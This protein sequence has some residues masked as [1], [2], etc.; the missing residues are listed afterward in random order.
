[1]EDFF[2]TSHEDI[3]SHIWIADPNIAMILRSAPTL[4]DARE[5]MFEHLNT[6][7]RRL[8]NIYSRK[9]LKDMHIVE[10]NNAKECIRVLKNFIRTENERITGYSAL[11]TLRD[12]A[13]GKQSAREV[14]KGFLLE[15]YHLFMG[16]N[17]RSGIIRTKLEFKDSEESASEKRSRI[18][19]EYSCRM[20]GFMRRYARGTDP[21]LVDRSLE[22]KNK[23]LSY[24]GG[25]DSDWT[26]HLWHL[27]H[28]V[29]DLNTLKNIVK[30]DQGERE[31]LEAARDYGIPVQI[32]PY[33]LTLFDPEGRN[34]SD[35]AIRAQVL[36]TR[37][38]CETVHSKREGDD[39]MDFMGERST[40]PID[41]IN[42]R[43]PKVLILKPFDSCPQIC[44]YCQRNWEIKSIDEGKVTRDNVERAIDWIADHVSISE[45]LI[46]GGDPLTLDN[47][48]IGHIMANLSDI[49]H[50]ERIRIGS[51]IPV[52]LPFRIDG[53]LIDIFKEFHIP[54]KREVCLV[55][56]FEHAA[57]VTPDSIAA[58]T[59]VRQAGMSVYNQ[60]VFTYFNS[61]K[62]ETAA[63]RRALKLSGV[64]PYYSFNTKGK[65]ETDD[66]RVPISR[67]I[68]E[69]KEEARLQPGLTR[70]DEPVFNVPKL[71]KTHLRAWQDHEPI[72][73]LPTGQRVYRFYPWEARMTL[74]DDYIHT[75]VSI[76]KY[77]NRLHDDG[78][79]ISDY[80]TIWYY[81]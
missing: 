58:I 54:G 44:V 50:I 35:R 17:G 53:G 10:K 27:R 8:F 77:L 64:D 32:T 15:F 74:V 52:T 37:R 56:H 46:T 26:D 13:R 69:R 51:R 63:L 71:G 68:Q 72:M 11:R 31:G 47:D 5:G 18:L 70:T 65:E 34:D 2:E 6:M 61:R 73:V 20:E 81:F 55:T 33:Y 4:S 66:F 25:N 16:M 19:D 29:K 22:M 28:I 62:F 80:R 23:I 75:D 78:E 7:E 24:F 39:D 36:P 38:Y 48:Y 30:L 79:D 41:C 42:R 60:Q 57:E 14:D 67:M 1:M 9:N 59:R 49:E 12:L 3:I 45:V 43:Y 76:W 21:E 40:S